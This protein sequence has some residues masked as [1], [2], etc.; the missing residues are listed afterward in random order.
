MVCLIATV[1]GEK[2]LVVSSIE[3]GGVSLFY[4]QSVNVI[5]HTLVS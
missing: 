5:R 3:E 1:G 4:H 2:V